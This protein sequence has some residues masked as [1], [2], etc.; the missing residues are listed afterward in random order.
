MWLLAVLMDSWALGL[1]LLWSWYFKKHLKIEIFIS[2]PLCT[3]E[4]TKCAS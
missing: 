4:E 3:D 2:H 1:K